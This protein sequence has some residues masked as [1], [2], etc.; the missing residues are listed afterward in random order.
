MEQVRIYQA[1]TTLALI[2]LH[3]VSRRPSFAPIQLTPLS[4]PL[5]S[6]P[7]LLLNPQRRRA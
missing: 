3:R 4:E 1:A 6:V 5:P 7:E 2:L